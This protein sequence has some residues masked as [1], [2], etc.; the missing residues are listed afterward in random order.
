VPWVSQLLPVAVV[1]AKLRLE[2][3]SLAPASMTTVLTPRN[4]IQTRKV[5][6]V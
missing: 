1:T 6:T 3:D 2:R 5:S 4:N